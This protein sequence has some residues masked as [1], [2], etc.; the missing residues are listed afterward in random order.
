MSWEMDL[1]ENTCMRDNGRKS[2]MLEAQEVSACS[3]FNTTENFLSMIRLQITS[4][5]LWTKVSF[6]GQSLNPKA[7]WTLKESGLKSRLLHSLELS[8]YFDDFD[9]KNSE[10]RVTNFPTVFFEFFSRKFISFDDD[11]SP[12]K[13]SKAYFLWSVVVFKL[14]LSIF[15]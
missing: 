10:N 9:P 4:H 8:C 1:L 11:L 13:I 3:S 5:T 14:S 15:M 6:I 7:I 12:L 2:A